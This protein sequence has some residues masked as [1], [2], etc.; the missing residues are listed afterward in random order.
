MKKLARRE[1]T[2]WIDTATFQ[3]V[4]VP[5]HVFRPVSIEG[6]VAQVEPGTQFELDQ[7][8]VGNKHP[9]PQP[10]RHE[11]RAKV[12]HIFSHRTQENE[13]YTGY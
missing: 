2:L 12:P 3:W 9:A 8:P 5:A 13:T 11:A 1:G 4:K 10:L 6:F 7:P